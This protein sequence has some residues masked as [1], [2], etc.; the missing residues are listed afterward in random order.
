MLDRLTARL[1]RLTLVVGLLVLTLGTACALAWQAH[2]AAQSHQQA[3][4]RVLGDYV[5]FAGWEFARASRREIESA[6]GRWL[7]VITC[8]ASTGPL[9]APADLA[10]RNGCKCD[11]L[12]AASLFAVTTSTGEFTSSGAAVTPQVRQW[13]QEIASR[14]P[15]TAPG[16]HAGIVLAETID[17]SPVALAGRFMRDPARGAVFGGFIAEPAVFA[18]AFAHVVSHTPL[19][20]PA[21]AGTG[22]D[23][24]GISVATRG[25]FPVFES[26]SPG[27]TVTAQGVL[28]DAAGGFTY[29]VSLKPEAAGRLVIGG[30]PRSRLPLLLGL[31][32]LTAGLLGVAVMQLRREHDLS[33]LR[34]DFVSSVSH[35][36]RTPLAQIRLF[37]ETLLLG[38][39]RSEGEGRRSLEIIH[40]ESRRLAHLVE[41]VL[42]FARTERGA[43]QLSPVSTRM[44]DLA[45]EV[46]ETF[47]PLAQAA[48]ASMRLHVRDDTRALVD[49]GA[50]RQILLN[51]LDNAAKY[52][53]PGQTI[54]VTL[55]RRGGDLVIMVDDEG[56][57]VPREARER[58]WQP[59]ARLGPAA[60]SGI[61][62]TG[63]GLAVVR[64]LAALHGGTASVE[65]AP[66]GGARFAVTLPGAQSPGAEAGHVVSE[67][68]VP[69]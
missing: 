11:D 29:R 42:Y 34:S 10:T 23:M 25:G 15:G 19:L 28:D 32:A 50:V 69:A 60:S 66:G 12:N 3:A 17:G 38:R 41:N 57:G 35:E 56:P 40:Q 2:V 65:D 43:Q 67:S 24:L 8:A 46:M 53:R 51:L 22:N 4:E 31:L 49:P 26:A 5:G 1:P 52:G 27:A 14:P 54:T 6:V 47:G 48:R 39:V 21:L 55:D 33:R 59:Y 61:A 7:D 62:G 13:I 9:P 58:I 68:S 20:P 36:L 45:S 44:A 30:L 37:S 64:D 16:A 18:S 63:I